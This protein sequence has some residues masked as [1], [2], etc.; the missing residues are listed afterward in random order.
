MAFNLV[1]ETGDKLLLENNKGIFLEEYVPPETFVTVDIDAD[2][3]VVTTTL[4]VNTP[5]FWDDLEVEVDDAAV[6][7]N[8]WYSSD[9]EKSLSVDV[10]AGE[11]QVTMT[12][13]SV[14]SPRH[15]YP[16]THYI[17]V[18]D[19]HGNKVNVVT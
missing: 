12:G 6:T 15:Y 1:L 4:R 7:V 17:W 8:E 3:A 9:P 11:A 5:K 13:L 14:T 18:Y 19:V 2:P 16:D 10:Q